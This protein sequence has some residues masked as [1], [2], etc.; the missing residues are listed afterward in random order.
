MLGYRGKG[1][2]SLLKSAL[3]S[4]AILGLLAACEDTAEPPAEHSPIKAS[5]PYPSSLTYWVPMDTDAAVTLKNYG[6]MGLYKQLTKI[7]GTRVT[8]Q[9]PPVGEEQAQDQFHLMMAS[10]ELPDVIYTDWSKNSPDKAIQDGRI[11]RL[12]ELIEQY[13][14]N[15]SRLLDEKPY[16]RK[17]LTSDEGNIYMFPSIGDDPPLFAY[18][19]LMLR[20]DWLD[21]LHL[22]TPVTIDDWEK[23]LTAFRDGDPNGNGRKDEI[24]FFYRQTDMETSYPFI[25]AF[26][27]TTGFYQENGVVKYGPAQPAFKTFLTLMNKWYAEGLIDRNYLTSD[28]KIRD[29]RMLDN[30]LGAV[31]GWAG[32]GL[33][34]YMQAMK[35]KLP[36]FN[37][38]G[39]PFPVLKVGGTAVSMARPLIIGL[40]AAISA[41]ANHPERIAAWLDYGYGKEGSI[42]YNFG[43][44]GESYTIANGK[45]QYTDLILHN[46]MGLTVSQA[47]SNYSLQSASGP[48]ATDPDADK[49][50]H[51][52]PEQA[53]A[54]VK[55]TQADHSKALPN[56]LLNA[57]EQEQFA[58]IMAD[59]LTYKDEM[60]NKFIMGAEPL[61]GFD[62]Y[63][64]KLNKL[65]LYEVVR[66]NQTAYERYSKK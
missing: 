59:L 41:K 22:K 27:I 29:G 61:S 1:F 32:S 60:V 62:D 50:W 21:K 23:V 64:R 35:E 26:G 13:A 63:V 46:P 18:H 34:A 12:N 51:A 56:G 45:P 30:Q 66:I 65:G 3:L 48:F 9:H 38:S 28:I 4:C 15:L 40:G 14:P 20:K 43:V 6:E 24:P 11:L 2:A 49:Q 57:G 55:W 10:G 31:A 53:D 44:E 7:T 58:S 5:S 33:G 16:L 39:V 17:E 25:G 8:F 19:G 36:G 52:D 37:L 47:L 42:L 54:M